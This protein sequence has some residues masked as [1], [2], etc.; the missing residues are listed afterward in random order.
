MGNPTGTDSF[1]RRYREEE[2]PTRAHEVRLEEG[3]T[4]KAEPRHLDHIP[5]RLR[6]D[7]ANAHFQEVTRLGPFGV[8][9]TGQGM[10]HPV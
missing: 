2:R 5:E 4:E 3:I 1:R 9:R 6:P 10:G 8:H 7:L